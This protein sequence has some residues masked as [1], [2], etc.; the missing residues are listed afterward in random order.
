MKRLLLIALVLSCV[1]YIGDYVR[2]RYKIMRNRT[3]FG[4]VSV[5]SYYAV[6]QKSRKT[7][8]YFNQPETL[9]CIHSLFPHFGYSPCWY[10]NRKKV[11]QI[12]V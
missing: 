11:Q 5:Q 9:P 10:L 12:K 3:P 7:E 4:A 6:P 1:L 2:I 8:L